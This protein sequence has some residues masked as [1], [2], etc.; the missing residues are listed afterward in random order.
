MTYR[1]GKLKPRAPRLRFSS[2]LTRPLPEPPL[3][4][5]LDALN[6]TDDNVYAND[7]VGDCACAGPAHETLFWERHNRR[8]PADITDEDVLRMYSDVTGYD[9]DDP[10]T[11]QGSCVSDVVAYRRTHGLVDHAGV[12]HTIAVGLGLSLTR[13]AVR[14]AI[15]LYDV[16]GLGI[17]VPESLMEQTQTAQNG[18]TAPEWT[19]VDGSPIDGGHYIAAIAYD[20]QWLYVNS[21]GIICRM[22]WDF[23]DH[24]VD[25]AWA[26]LSQEDVNS[27]DMSP[28]GI[29]YA[30]LKADIALL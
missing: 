30:Q 23:F 1:L 11:D 22:S 20:E 2:Y 12:A 14:Q 5:N 4:A 26:Y 13:D 9:P 3:T 27:A 17:Q 18:H 19:V 10:S 6:L 15:N 25:E 21:W 28:D 16:C 24:Y 8:D 29:D 7:S